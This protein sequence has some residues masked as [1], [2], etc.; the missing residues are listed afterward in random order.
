MMRQSGSG[1][2]VTSM[3]MS[4]SMSDA[5]HNYGSMSKKDA[6]TGNPESLHGVLGEDRKTK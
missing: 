4:M 1:P 2:T 3:S 6:A 5:A